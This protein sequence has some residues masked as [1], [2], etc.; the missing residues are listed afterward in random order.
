MRLVD[1]N[2]YFKKI[3]KNN[4]Q[5]NYLNENINC[6]ILIIGAGVS[7]AI[8]AYYMA[9]EGYNVV[10]VDKNIVGYGSTSANIGIIDV[11]LGMEL[12]K[13]TKIIGE[14]KTKKCINLMI[15]SIDELKKIV[16]KLGNK[17]SINFKRTNSVYY[18]DKYMNK[19]AIV[20]E[21]NTKINAGIGAKFLNESNII[22]LKYGIELE[23]ASAT[24]NIYEFTK[25][26]ISYISKKENVR[27][28]EHTEAYEIK[29]KED[30]VDV[31]TNNKFKIK[32]NKV[33]I[34][35]GAEVIKYF[36]EIPIE[37][38]KTYN[39]VTEPID[40][41][42]N[43][44]TNFTARNTDVPF[45]YM[46]FT[47]DDRIIFGGQMTRITAK[48]N[49]DVIAKQLSNSRY[50]KLF[51]TL[52]ETFFGLK[53]INVKCCFSGVF[54]ETKDSLPIIDEIIGMPNVYC[55]LSYG[56]NGIL[57]SVVGAKMLKEINKEYY[58][59]DMHMFGLKR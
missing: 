34:T 57:F 28:Y 38:Y 23:D 36:P 29:S 25:E 56:I 4:E 46:R 35:E 19:N 11:Q 20:K 54:A 5:Y 9:E 49:N 8:T 12:S 15:D 10:V 31:I 52:Q 44:Y 42:K 16:S 2:L 3:S 45:N 26:I 18:T 58:A 30:Y 33:I 6:D 41:L 48:E 37:L 59:R 55:N 17:N 53:D 22:D 32:A 51:K 27:V 47:E 1:G 7:G 43:Y 14:K 50:R 24:M 40:S 21:Y 39:I 13:L